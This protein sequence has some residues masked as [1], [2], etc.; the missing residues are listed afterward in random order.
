[1]IINKEPLSMAEALKYVKK[2]EAEETDVIGFIKK[3]VKIKKEEASKLKEKLKNLE[4]MKVR[5]EH[6][7]KIIDLM[8]ENA[9]ELNK[10]FTDVSLD[11]DEA[12]KILNT[13]KET[14]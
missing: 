3:F 8:P 9:E 1:M 10:I 6:I 13:I 14:K 11:D 12:Q 2:E 7:T 4:M 5:D